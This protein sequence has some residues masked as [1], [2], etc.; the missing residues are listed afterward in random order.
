MEEH[1]GQPRPEVQLTGNDG[2][3]FAVMANVASALRDAGCSEE[4]ISAYKSES[5]SGDYNNLLRVACKY[6]VVE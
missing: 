3:A 4:H 1:N 6:A 2:N 5:M